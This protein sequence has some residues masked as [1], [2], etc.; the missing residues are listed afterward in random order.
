L[1]VGGVQLQR[2][3]I[4]RNGVIEAALVFADLSEE[5]VGGGMIGELVE[6]FRAAAFGVLKG[7]SNATQVGGCQQWEQL[8][9][10]RGAGL[11]F[12]CR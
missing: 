10:R 2:K 9:I 7:P 4:P 8:R 1:F 11:P 3:L 12:G 6:D 5:R